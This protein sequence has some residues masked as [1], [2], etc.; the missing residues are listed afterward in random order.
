MD[1][2]IVADLGFDTYPNELNR[3]IDKVLILDSKNLSTLI[4]WI[5]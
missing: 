2:I 1:P 5:G 3:W 4:K